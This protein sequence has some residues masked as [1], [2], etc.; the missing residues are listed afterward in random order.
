MTRLLWFVGGYNLLAGVGMFCFYHEG[1]KLL[2]VE[3]PQLNLPIQLV[4][5]LVGLFGVG[6]WMVASNPVENRNILLLG[7]WSKAMGSAL[8]IYYVCVGKLPTAFLAMLFFSDIVYLP[9]FYM[10]LRRLDSH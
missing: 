3:K 7:F 1:F 9:P 2:G 6:Y 5:M 4:G 10:I 8:G